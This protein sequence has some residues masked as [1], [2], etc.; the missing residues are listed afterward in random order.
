MPIGGIVAVG[1]DEV[2][3]GDVGGDGGRCAAVG[4]I[5]VK[6]GGALHLC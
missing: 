2:V 5:K 4:V 6:A 1:R 3:A